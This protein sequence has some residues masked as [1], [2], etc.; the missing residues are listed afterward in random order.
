MKMQLRSIFEGFTH[1]S[2]RAKLIYTFGSLIVIIIASFAII[3]NSVSKSESILNS[4]SNQENATV[5]QL[6]SLKEHLIEGKYL[7]SMWVYKRTDDLSKQELSAYLEKYESIET[8]LREKAKSWNKKDSYV[9]DTVLTLSNQVVQSQRNVTTYLTDFDSYEDLLSMMSSETEIE[10]IQA[11]TQAVLPMLEDLLTVKV[12]EEKQNNVIDVLT[13]I[14]GT[15]LL[16]S[17]VIIAVGIIASIYLS[18]RILRPIKSTAEL[19]DRVVEGDLRIE[20]EEASNDEMGHLQQKIN[21]MVGKFKEVLSFIGESSQ[22]IKVS[23]QE[24]RGFSSDLFRGAEN[25]SN[26]VEQVAASME[27]M[28]SNIAL[29]ASNS[30]ETQKL[31]IE[32][33]EGVQE[34]YKSASETLEAMNVI[35]KKISIIG[36]IARQ[37]NLL[38]LNAAVEA[39]RA[40][41]HGRGFAVVAAEIRKLAE[42]SQIASA[43]IDQASGKGIEISRNS[44]QLLQSL[45]SKIN[46]TV[47]L[48]QQIT[49][50]SEEQNVGASQVNDSIQSLN[51]IVNRNTESA[52]RIKS[53]SENLDRLADSLQENLAFFKIN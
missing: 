53:N 19:I 25:Q 32:S 51:L 48:V 35:T 3:W 33:G 9:L 42:R 12:N 27:E 15:I 49:R 38:A 10:N 29:N 47:D 39:A 16:I 52:S 41:E 37:T 18:R 26:S 21:Q 1:A 17:F 31:A 2:F 50:A 11:T 8:G 23:S 13:T 28:S 24:M 30:S 20:L 4:Q 22:N 40:G 14:K 46:H 34:S 6:K 45:V 43:E 44:S 5:V 7:T 36:E